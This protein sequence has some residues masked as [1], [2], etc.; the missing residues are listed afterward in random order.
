[1]AEHPRIALDPDVLA[2]KPVIRGTRLAVEFVI[3][4][5]AD[6]WTEAETIANYPGV[7]HED[8]LACLAYARDRQLSTLSGH[9]RRPKG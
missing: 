5:L 6:G 2:G 8:I 7:A 9:S 1:M 3:G 4:L